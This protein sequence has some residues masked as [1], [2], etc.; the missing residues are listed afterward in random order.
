MKN[1]VIDLP[2]LPTATEAAQRRKKRRKPVKSRRWERD[3]DPQMFTRGERFDMERT[4][5]R[6]ALRAYSTDA[7]NLW[8][9]QA[10][11]E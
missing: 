4:R 5:A 10:C 1:E 9:A 2:E 11:A 3:F 7:W 8:F 6:E